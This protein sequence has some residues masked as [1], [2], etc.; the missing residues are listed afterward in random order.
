MKRKILIATLAFFLLITLGPFLVPVNALPGTQPAAALLDP[1]DE[2]I[3]LDDFTAHV[4]IMGQGQRTILLLHGLGS[5]LNTWKSVQASLSAQF[6]VIAVDLPGYGLTR[7]NTMGID[8]S[9]YS[10]AGRAKFV[11]D[12]MDKIGVRECILVGNSAGGK[13][14][15][16]LAAQHPER[17][18]KLIL[19]DPDIYGGGTPLFLKPVFQ[20]PQMDHLGPLFARV[21]IKQWIGLLQ[22]NRYDPEDDPQGWSATYQ[23]PQRAEGWD[24]E[25]WQLIRNSGETLPDELIS[26]IQVPTLILQGEADT[27][28]KEAD[29]RK[30]QTKIAGASFVILPGSAH[31]PQEENPDLLV[32]EMG[33]FISQ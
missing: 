10:L 32:E 5:T 16:Y 24:R 30:A 4:R 1:G 20:T 6:K 22:T 15:A 8:P 31:L 11:I 26:S 12:L 29:S 27:L 25:L 21:F 3:E 18:E 28:V 17:F 7:P 33:R 2:Q 23:S 14:A 9:S 19:V 13:L